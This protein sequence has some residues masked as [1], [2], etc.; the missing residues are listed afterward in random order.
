MGAA[1]GGMTA[2]P[3]QQA[4]MAQQG[5]LYG[6]AGA[7]TVAGANLNPYMNPYTKNVIGGL[8]TEANRAMQMGANQL[9]AQATQAKAFGGSRHGIAQGQMMGDI[10][11]GLNQQTGQ[12]LQSGYQNAQTMAQQDIQNRMNQAAQLGNLGQQSFGYGQQ[13][14]GNLA[15]QG[16]AQQVLNQAIIDAAKGQYGAYQAAPTSGLSIMT[17]ALGASPHGQTQTTQRQ[18]GIM[19]YLTAGATIAGMSD[20]RLKVNIQEYGKLS[21]GIKTYTWDWTEKGRELAGDQ[22][23]HGVI[24]QEVAEIFPDAVIVGDDGYMRVNYAHPELKGAI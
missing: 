22:I 5:A 20:I 1:A 17:Q 11:R 15:Q 9:G 12:L 4:S 8:Q 14:Q 18:L 19:D 23:G 10:Q 24:A 13:I 7:G 6:T 16:Q 2:N 21:N 3:M